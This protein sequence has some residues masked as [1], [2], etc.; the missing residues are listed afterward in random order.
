MLVGESFARAK[1]IVNLALDENAHLSYSQF[2]E[3][4]LIDLTFH[5]K[6]TPGFYVDV[7]AHHPRRFSNTHLFYQRGWRGLNIEGDSR[8]LQQF[9]TERPEDININAFVSDITEEVTFNQFSDAAVNTI[10]A[11]KAEEYKNNWQVISS[12]TVITRTL[13]D[14]LN[15]HFPSGR[16]IDFMT[17]DC[18]GVDLKVLRG[19]DWSKFKPYLIVVEAEGLNI[20]DA[21]ANPTVQ[22]LRTLGYHLQH[23]AHVSAFFV[24]RG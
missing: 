21:A 6:K 20:M 12:Q 7:G 11:S 22:Y 15:E 19:N 16:G 10:A 14:I 2:G 5:G 1:Q 8:L 18:E 24:Y 9:A 4:L 3:D 17:V 23:V 13:A